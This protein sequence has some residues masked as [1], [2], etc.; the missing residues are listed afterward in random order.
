MGAMQASGMRAAI[1]GKEKRPGAHRGRESHPRATCACGCT[2]EEEARA[3]GL[4]DS[5]SV[6]WPTC[7]ASE[8]CVSD[9]TYSPKPPFNLQRGRPRDIQC[10]LEAGL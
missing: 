4:G 6:S 2:E 1:V 5:G 3:R 10:N 8:I 7:S 9:P